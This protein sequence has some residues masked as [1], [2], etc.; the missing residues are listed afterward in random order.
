MNRIMLTLT[1]GNKVLASPLIAL[2]SAIISEKYPN[3]ASL[4]TYD[5]AKK[6]PPIIKANAEAANA[7]NSSFESPG[8]PF[9]YGTRVI[10][11]NSRLD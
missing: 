5:G 10:H 3:E 7:I 6:V 1:F 4:I 11:T 8:L 2:Y 9:Q